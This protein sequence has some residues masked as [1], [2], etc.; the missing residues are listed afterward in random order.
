MRGVIVALALLASVP[1]AHALTEFAYVC[2]VYDP[3]PPANV[4]TPPSM[5]GKIID[6]IPNG[7]WVVIHDGQD[8][9]YFT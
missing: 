5:K 8:G 3:R 6:A 9:W 4:R 7:K 2:Q 1:S